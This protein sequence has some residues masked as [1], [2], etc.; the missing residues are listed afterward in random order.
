MGICNRRTT[1][2]GGMHRRSNAA[3]TFA[4][5]CQGVHDGLRETVAPGAAG[6]F[7]RGL[8]F[9]D[10]E[11]SFGACRSHNL[12]APRPQSLQPVEN[13]AA[14]GAGVPGRDEPARDRIP[15][16]R[17]FPQAHADAPIAPPAAG[18][19]HSRRL[20]RERRAAWQRH[21]AGADARLPGA[22]RAVSVEP[23]DHLRRGGGVAP[24]P[25]G[26]L[27]SRAHE[28]RRGTGRVPG[29]D[30][31]RSG[32]RRRRAGRQRP[33]DHP[34][35]RLHPR[36][37]RAAPGR[38][39]VRRGRSRPPAAPP[40]PG[41]ARREARR[42]PGA[43]AR[44]HR[45]PRH[46]PRRRRGVRGGARE[47]PLRRGRR[48]DRDRERPL[49]RH[50]PRPPLGPHAARLRGDDPRPGR[51][52]HRPGGRRRTRL[53]PRHHRRVHRAVRHHHR[54]R[55]AGGAAVRRR[56]GRLLQLPGRSRPPVDPRAGLRRLR[57]LRSDVA[58][59]PA[60]PDLDRV[61]R[62]VRPARGLSAPDLLGQ[63]RRGPRG[64]RPNQ[65]AARR[66]GEVRPRDVLLQLRRRAAAPPARIAS[67]SR[68]RPSRPTT[69][70]RR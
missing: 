9:D 6:C 20:G 67:S 16:F 13:E 3:G 32:D 26:Q 25:D 39:A 27:G 68:P 60:R 47:L 48:T 59:G 23:A 5:G 52:Q 51:P 40:C 35:R 11:R 61:R 57:R 7:Y 45:R 31:H 4:T 22:L 41:A 28:P 66:D 34:A 15:G 29:S 37:P 54:R 10:R 30:P 53:R 50:G 49:L 64:A 33:A 58:A 65:P 46:R 63:P 69:S 12:V 38:A 36:R 2:S 56:R 18:A 21:P 1:Q 44:D 55:P 70:S 42:R 24:R 17:P 8:G 62:H 43:R 14:S 19:R